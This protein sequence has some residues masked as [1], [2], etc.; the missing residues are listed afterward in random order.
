MRRRFIVPL[1]ILFL[2][3]FSPHALAQ[4]T[5]QPAGGPGTSG[6]AYRGWGAQV[7]LS[8]KPDQIY[9]GVHWDLGEFARN[10]RFRPVVEIGRGDHATLVQ[11]LADVTYIFS[12]VQVWHPYVGGGVGF[13][14]V[15]IDSSQLPPGA[16]NTDTALALMGVGGVETK[17]RSGTKFFLEARVGFGDDDPDF[18]IGAGWTWK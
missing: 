10:V 3:A 15:N 4:T 18:K 6:I 2:A 1:F 8:N 13:T 9:G 5:G 7:G 16:D 11:A 14:Y 12:K 17:L